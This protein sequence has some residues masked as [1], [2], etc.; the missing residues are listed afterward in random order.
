MVKAYDEAGV[1]LFV[2]KRN[3]RNTTLPFLKKAINAGRFGRIYMVTV[4]VF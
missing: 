3:R 2:V 1:H 4:N